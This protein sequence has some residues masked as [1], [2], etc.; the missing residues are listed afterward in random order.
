MTSV[1]YGTEG[2]WAAAVVAMTDDQAGNV[3]REI[4]DLAICRHN[5]EE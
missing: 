3:A 5:L 4:F 2:L 1:R